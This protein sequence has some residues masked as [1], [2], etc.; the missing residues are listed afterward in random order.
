MVKSQATFTSTMTK[1]QP[2]DSEQFVLPGIITLLLV[3]AIL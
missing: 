1:S 3:S 2:V